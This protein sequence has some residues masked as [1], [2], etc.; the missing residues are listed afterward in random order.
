MKEKSPW[1]NEMMKAA[2]ED[3]PEQTSVPDFEALTR[4]AEETGRPA[5]S[6]R[7][8]RQ[9]RIWLIPAAAAVLAAAIAT[10]LGIRAGR[11]AEERR[12]DQEIQKMFVE[13][14]I[15]DSLF[16]EGLTSEQIWF[17]DIEIDAG[18]FEI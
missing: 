5:D 9:T 16:D 13:G 14:L 18:F 3:S 4:A 2:L 10:P 11:R 12:I 1:L 17:P 7:R 6:A 8:F 15:G